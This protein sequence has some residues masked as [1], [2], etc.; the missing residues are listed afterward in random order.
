MTS[1]DKNIIIEVSSKIGVDPNWLSALIRFESGFNPTASNPNS[2]AKGLI[3]FIDSTARDLGFND[4][5]DLV[6]ELPTFKE[7][8]Q[9]A[10][11]PYLVQF[12]PYYTEQSLYM[13]VFYPKFRHVA[14]ETVFPDSVQ[15]VNPGIV[16]VQDYIDLVKKKT[17]K[18]PFPA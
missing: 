2:S 7:Q 12:A 6:K 14:P 11:Y 1:E 8:M 16:T 18:Q 3:Q 13:A 17:L 4:S 9:F 15:R 10:V 5:A